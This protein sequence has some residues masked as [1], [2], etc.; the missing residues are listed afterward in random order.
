MALE[1]GTKLGPYEILSPLGAGGMGEVYLA[2]D[3]KLDR[4]VAIKVLPETMTRDK[5]RVARFEREAK[6]LA[7]LNHP[8]IAAIHG[9]DDSDGSRFLV[10]EYVEG[11][12]LGSHLGNGAMAIEDALDIAKQIAEALEA[13]HG[14]GVIHR[15]LKPA[16]VMIRPDGTVK[17]LD[18]G[19]A[20]AMAEEASGQEVANSPTITAN[21]TR[22][23]VVLGTAAYMS[24]EQARGRALD[25]R[26]DI[27][28]FGII[29]FECLSGGRLFRGETANDSM[30]AIMHKDP[31]WSLLPPGTPPTIQLLLRRCLTKDRK[32]RLHDIAD[33]RVELE[34]AIVDPS[35]SS[36]G[37]AR[38][39]V[40][41]KGRRE[42][43]WTVVLALA[44]LITATATYLV[45]SRMSGPAPKPAKLV[46]PSTTSQYRSASNWVISPDGRTL[47]FEATGIQDG[48]RRLWTRPLDS[49][50]A[51]PLAETQ[52]ASSCFWSD[53]SQSIGFN[54]DEKLWSVSLRGGAKQ[55]LAS[56]RSRHG[57]T[58]HGDVIILSVS[59]EGGLFRI[60]ASGGTPVAVTSLDDDSFE[61]IHSS[62]HFLPDGNRFLFLSVTFDPA[63][64]TRSHT[65]FAGS[66]D[67]DERIL[68]GELTSGA[69]Y[70]DAGFLVYVDNG[71]VK[72]VP[73]DEGSLE[74]TGKPSIVS[75]GAFYFSAIGRSSL[76]V[77]RDGSIV[78][79]PPQAGDQL[80]WFD[81]RGSQLSRV[82]EKGSVGSFRLS[83]SGSDVAVS[84]VDPRTS[85]S[86]IWING[87]RRAT[88]TRLTFD[89]RW[90]GHPVW[91]PDGSTIYFSWDRYGPPD[92]FS[93]PVQGGS[94]PSEIYR[95][96]GNW[97][98]TD[99]SLD[100]RFLLITGPGS[101]GTGKDVWVVPLDDKGDPH[102]FVATRANEQRG[103]FS[104]DGKWV[105]YES[106]AS[107]EWQVYVEAFPG[108]GK[109]VQIS[110]HGGSDPV[111]AHD[112]QSL[113]FEQVS[114]GS[115]SDRIIVVDLAN[116]ED[117]DNPKPRLLFDA[118]RPIGGFDVA[119]D[120][121][122]FLLKLMPED[123]PP[124][125][126]I[127]NWN[128]ESGDRE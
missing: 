115:E 30:G 121:K 80:A 94:T 127:L 111:W 31:E 66:L 23:G 53:D 12:T 78:F 120:G 32:R 83:P 56:T 119:H 116:P 42:N 24:P 103:R 5:E 98:P 1:A 67:S 36:L 22:P 9:F 69:W 109:R 106:D 43:S 21:Y 59:V 114:Q 47:V 19:L 91:A 122:Q 14:Q 13:A 81:A 35:S 89:T 88:S 38:L 15:D 4:R 86:D 112:G 99:V 39:A 102:A 73:F 76:S 7:S 93:L 125:H 70:A 50:A 75:D 123:T 54:Q 107:G 72:A 65:L 100:G 6:L 8:N 11:Q 74:I 104:P 40:E 124:A 46:L 49:F 110:M 45:T 27:W 2:K 33:A 108:P 95:A 68:V 64:E 90:E 71:T 87:L 126:V 48:L 25:K 85:S 17:V 18:F 28:S 79:E 41:E 10:M 34:D 84:L 51:T 117:Y 55:L 128:A 52:E 82:V 3:S 96:P 57:A 113:F 63:K 77:S 16:N 44:M 92:T 29:L 60:P 26:T 97:S 101:A 37:L 61:V 105:A 58:W 20:K 62:P 118:G